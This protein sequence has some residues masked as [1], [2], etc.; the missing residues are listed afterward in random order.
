M[1]AREPAAVQHAQVLAD[2]VKRDAPKL[3]DLLFGK[4]AF[5]DSMQIPK[6]EYHAMLR[7]AWINGVEVKDKVTTP[8]EWRA[9]FLDRVGPEKF[10]NDACEAFGIP[11]HTALLQMNDASNDP[12]IQGS[13]QEAP[14][15]DQGAP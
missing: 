8:E 6:P 11:P 5:T 1:P 13:P 14:P 2:E 15:P 3:A 10:W 9:Q 4:N 7:H 12:T